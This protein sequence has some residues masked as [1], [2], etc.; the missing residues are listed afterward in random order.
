MSRY[1]VIVKQYFSKEAVHFVQA[2]TEE[3]A[4]GIALEQVA[5]NWDNYERHGAQGLTW[6]GEDVIV[7][8]EKL[9]E[10][11]KNGREIKG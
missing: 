1:R 6:E 2:G 11:D 5:F 7:S 8:T 9:K 4:D 3:E 10:W